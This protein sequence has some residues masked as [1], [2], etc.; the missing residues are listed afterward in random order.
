M[1]AVLLTASLGAMGCGDNEETPAEN[2][3]ANATTPDAGPGDAG[4]GTSDNNGPDNHGQN[5]PIPDAGAEDAEQPEEDAAGEEDAGGEDAN[6]EEDTSAEGTTHDV[7]IAG[8]AFNPLEITIKVGDTV[9]WTN[10]DNQ[11]H[12]STSGASWNNPDGGWDSGHLQKDA[13]FEHT[14]E[15]AGEFSY[16]CIPHPNMALGTVVVED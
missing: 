3:T 12:T 16:Y 2:Q 4:D 13:S 1:T 14:F 9:R 7:E 8:F 5:N 15:A 6:G 10:K 11:V